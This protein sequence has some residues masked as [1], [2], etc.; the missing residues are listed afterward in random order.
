L[1]GDTEKNSEKNTL[2]N[3]E[4]VNNFR[5]QEVEHPIIS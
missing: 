1:P 5:L 2:K 3:L 4:V